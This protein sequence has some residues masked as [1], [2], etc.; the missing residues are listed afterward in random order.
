MF[1]GEYPATVRGAK[2]NT[3]N[4]DAVALAKKLVRYPVNGRRRTRNARAS[5]GCWHTL[6]G[7]RRL[8]DGRDEV[9]LGPV[10]DHG[11]LFNSF[12]HV[13]QLD[14]LQPY[15]HIFRFAVELALVGHEPSMN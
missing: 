12:F 14:F 13:L 8:T 7:H 9:L 11:F 2:G 6:Y 4:P 3:R 5:V 1:T 15:S 10:F